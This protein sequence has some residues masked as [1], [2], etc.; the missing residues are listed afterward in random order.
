MYVCENINSFIYIYTVYRFLMLVL[1]FFEVFMDHS[2]L[3]MAYIWPWPLYW[4]CV[5]CI[6]LLK[7]PWWIS[8]CA[9]TISYFWLDFS[10]FFAF[11]YFYVTYFARNRFSFLQLTNFSFSISIAISF[12]ITIVVTYF[13]YSVYVFSLCNL[14]LIVYIQTYQE[15]IG[16]NTITLL[17]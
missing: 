8:Y 11:L 5:I 12:F 2:I 3:V 1:F 16:N 9:L 10:W 4:P 15:C 7:N 6:T 13:I 17:N 14:I